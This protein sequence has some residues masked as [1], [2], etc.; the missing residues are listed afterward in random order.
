MKHLLF[1]I[2]LTA[3]VTARAGDEALTAEIDRVG[4]ELKSVILA[5]RQSGRVQALREAADRA[6]T[7][8]EEAIEAIPGV[9]ELDTRIADAHEQLR[10]L[11]RERSQIVGRHEA[12]IRPKREARDAA[13][14]AYLHAAQGGDRGRELAAQRLELFRQREAL[15]AS[16]QRPSHE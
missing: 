16:R 2:L 12:A 5:A 6:A 13:Q 1:G 15:P 9:R 11:K 4:R 7:E 10:A 8:H 3:A 14:R